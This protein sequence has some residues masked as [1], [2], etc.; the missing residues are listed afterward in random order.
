MQKIYFNLWE[1]FLR[2]TVLVNKIFLLKWMEI[3]PSK[4]FEDAQ[5]KQ[6]KIIF[7]RIY[8][9]HFPKAFI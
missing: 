1:I 5:S 7:H 8:R 6:G 3:T 9:V 4:S 2:Y